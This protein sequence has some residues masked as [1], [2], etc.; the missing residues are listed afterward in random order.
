MVNNGLSKALMRSMRE[1]FSK[2]MGRIRSLEGKIHKLNE[3][4]GEKSFGGWEK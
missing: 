2:T 4:S 3:K 1:R